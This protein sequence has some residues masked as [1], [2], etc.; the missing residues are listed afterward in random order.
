MNIKRKQ[1]LV[2]FAFNF[3]KL[4]LSIGSKNGS[5]KLNLELKNIL[6]Q[7]SNFY[8]ADGKTSVINL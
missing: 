1:L 3:Y 7:N 2:N 8:L 4:V 5:F 6:Y